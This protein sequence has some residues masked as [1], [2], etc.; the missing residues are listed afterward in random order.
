[1]L[2]GSSW[3]TGSSSITRSRLSQ[4]GGHDRKL[5]RSRGVKAYAACCLAE[6]LR[7]YAP[8][9]PYTADELRDIFQFFIAQITDGLKVP[10]STAR[11]PPTKRGNDSQSQSTQTQLSQAQ[12]QG[13]RV[14]DV[15]FYPE[16][17]HLIESLASIKSVVIIVDLPSAD[18]LI[19]RYFM[20]FCEIAR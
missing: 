10:S 20:G 19:T 17:C 5:T 4:R 11:P 3:S 12:T 7:L 14:T 13:S 18:D 16:Y 9:A 15:P 8:D 2:S 6:L 1:M